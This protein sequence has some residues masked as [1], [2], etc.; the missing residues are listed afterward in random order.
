LTRYSSTRSRRSCCAAIAARVPPRRRAAVG[1][2]R[3]CANC[4]QCLDG[5]YGTAPPRRCHH[6][7]PERHSL[8]A[9]EYD[10]SAADGRSPL[11]LPLSLPAHSEVLCTE[12]NRAAELPLKHCS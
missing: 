7:L 8:A 4:N 10:W 9:L 11:H 12:S 1:A 2:L 5:R 3:S 6:M